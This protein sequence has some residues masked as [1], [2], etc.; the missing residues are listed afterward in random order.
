VKESLDG[1]AIFERVKARYVACKT[2]S[3]L[4]TSQENRD[5]RLSKTK[6]RSFMIRFSRPD[7]ICVDWTE[8]KFMGLGTEKS[9]LYTVKGKVYSDSATLGGPKEYPSISHAIGVHA[10]VSNGISY[11]IPPLLLGEPGY[12]HHWTIT[13]GA[14]RSVDGVICYSIIVEPKGFGIYTFD[15]S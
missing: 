10:G 14:D 1:A 4:G 15:V 2:F 6:D 11:L 7:L 12:L 9:S 8:P 3:C 13:R 5:R